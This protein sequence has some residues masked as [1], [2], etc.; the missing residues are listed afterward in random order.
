MKSKQT[1]LILAF[2]GLTHAGATSPIHIAQ[3]SPLARPMHGFTMSDPS[4]RSAGHDG[5][6]AFSLLSGV[7]GLGLALGGSTDPDQDSDENP[8]DAHAWPEI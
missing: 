1:Q 5:V 7:I 2:A 8:P 3:H 6:W 4:A